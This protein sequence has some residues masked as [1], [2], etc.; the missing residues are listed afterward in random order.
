MTSAWVSLCSNKAK[1]HVYKLGQTNTTSY[2]SAMSS[3]VS[4]A[5]SEWSH[6]QFEVQPQDISEGGTYAVVNNGNLHVIT[7]NLKYYRAAID[8]QKSGLMSKDKEETLL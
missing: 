8:I 5:N 3:M 4:Y 1:I 7:K 2:F 6:C